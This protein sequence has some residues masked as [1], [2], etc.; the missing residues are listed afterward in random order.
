MSCRKIFPFLTIL[1]VALV[2]LYAFLAYDSRT[3]LVS[4]DP[5]PGKL[6]DADYVGSTTCQSC[7]Q[8]EFKDW[9][10]SH[11][12]QAMMEA[13]ENSVKGAFDTTFTSQG[14]TSRF[15][16]KGKR[17][18][19]NTEGPDGINQDFEVVYTYG[20]TPLQQYIVKFPDGKFQCLRMAW[21]VEK[22]TWFDLYGQDKIEPGEWIHWTGGALNWNTMCS[23]CHSTNVHKNFQEETESFRTTF[24]IMNVGCE[25]CHGPG[26]EH[27]EWV[28]SPDFEREGYG[29]KVQLYLTDALTSRQQVDQCARCHSRRVQ[30][31]EAFNHEGEFMDHYTPEIL[32]EGIYFPDGQIRDEVYVY[33]SFVQSKMYHNGVKC[34]NCH[35]PHSLDL[36]AIGNAL[37]TQCHAQEKFD[38][39]NHHFH[40]IETNGAE[41]VNCHMPGRTYMGNDFR[42]DHSFRVPR[43]DLSVKYNTPNACNQCHKDKSAAWAAEAVEKRYGPERKFHFSE[44]LAAG[45][46]GAGSVIPGLID[47][48]DDGSQP[49]IARATAIWYLDQ[50]MSQE[51]KEAIIRNLKSNENIIRHTA[52]TALAD[53]PPEEK[54]RH[55]AP[56]LKDK[57]RTVRIAAANALADVPEIQLKPEF[58]ADFHKALREYRTSLDIK[59]DF[60]GGQFEKGQFFERSGQLH[61]AEKAYLKAIKLDNHFNM[62]RLNLAYLYN[63]LRK[64]EQAMALFETVIEQEPNYGMAYYSLGL[65]YAEENKMAYALEYLAKAVELEDNPRIYYN[66]GIVYQQLGQLS[67]AEKTYIKGLQLEVNDFDLRYALGILYMQQGEMGKAKPHLKKL[68]KVQPQNSQLNRMWEMIHSR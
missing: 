55:L 43:P 20:I 21:D 26:K 23:D 54:S 52:V 65:L 63:R 30:H 57:I 39:P 3:I 53:L 48:S 29:E 49:A 56:L 10:L 40:V 66:L 12:D 33:G 67:Q 14:V 31:T 7:H 59:A 6:T 11:H 16:K 34:S 24:S 19:V 41:C 8:R 28:S 4:P 17:F 64:N 32:R 5:V 25:G 1:M 61:L 22:K 68:L 37:C 58:L 46:T 27:V 42:R 51:S 18:Y 44:I 9:Q 45:S 36:K 47:L 15:F 2:M 38:T 62:A 35:D 13:D 60:P 50:T